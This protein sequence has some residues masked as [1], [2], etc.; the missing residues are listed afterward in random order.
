MMP[1]LP[2]GRVKSPGREPH[3]FLFIAPDPNQDLKLGEFV[4]YSGQFDDAER[5]VFARISDRQPIR[6][7]PDS[8]L[9]DPTVD[10]VS[11]SQTVGYEV[12]QNELFQITAQII[13]YF[14]ASRQDFVNPRLSPR[15][16]TPIHVAPDDELTTVLSRVKPRAEGAANIGW[17][18]SRHKSAV[19][20]ALDINAIASMHL[21]I[22]AN[23]GAGKSY[24]ASVLIEEMLSPNNRAAVLVIDPHGEYSSLDEIANRPE[25]RSGDYHPQAKVHLPGS[26]KIRVGGLTQSDLGYLLPNLSDR[27]EYVLGRAYT[28]AQSAS[29]S[30]T[31]KHVDQWTLEELLLAVKT[32]GESSTEKDST[33]RDKGTAEALDWR[34]RSVLKTGTGRIFD[35]LEQ[36]R[37]TDL[38]RPGLC[39]V[40][41][42]N[43]VEPREQQVIVATLLRR[44]YQARLRTTREQLP[45]DDEYFLPYPVFVL[46]EEAHNFAPAGGGI[47]STGI[48]KQILAEGRKF[49]VAVGLI[50]QRPGKLDPDVLS[51]CNTQFLM[52]IVNPVDQARVAES[53]ESVG[54]ELLAELPGLNK[55]QAVISGTAVNTPVICQIRERWTP[56]GGE[57][58]DA[59]GNW[60]AYSRNAAGTSNLRPVFKKPPS[61]L[62]K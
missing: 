28:N 9:S 17:L 41:Q 35:D 44:I 46:I 49:G 22:I 37:L 6:L 48:L 32:S 43:Q 16:G 31:G 39:T 2:V 19:P 47:I 18:A 30:R 51:Q 50:S 40:M 59:V 54:R 29:R 8:F 58:Q 42:L 56:H 53:V 38:M 23:T 55:G 15:V 11:V 4:I 3:T 60:L 1:K 24:T 14:D 52:R 27:M 34:I 36:S 33:E 62:L 45:E 57:S 5:H 7:Y 61:G 21:A 26:V 25:M 13:G 12:P 20:I 10:P